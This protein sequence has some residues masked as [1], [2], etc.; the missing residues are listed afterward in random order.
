MR[1]DLLAQLCDGEA[2]RPAETCITPLKGVYIAMIKKIAPE[3]DNAAK[4]REAMAVTFLA[5]RGQSQ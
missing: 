5:R 4:N 3:I 2:D 1:F